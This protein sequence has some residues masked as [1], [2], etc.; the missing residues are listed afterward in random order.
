[1]PEDAHNCMEFGS[2][3]G[4][5][6][7][8]R[9]PK[10]VCGHG[11]PT[12]GVDQARSLAG[13]TQR[14]VEQIKGRHWPT[15]AEE[16][17]PH[18]RSGP[19]V[20]EWPLGSTAPQRNDCAQRVSGFFVKQDDPFLECLARRDSE[21]RCAVRVDVEAVDCQPADLATTRARPAGDQQRRTLLWTWQTIDGRHEASQLVGR[22]VARDVLR[23]ARHI[24]VI[25]Q[26]PAWHIGPA[27]AIASLKNAT[28][29]AM[30]AR[31]AVTDSNL[32]VTDRASS[33]MAATKP[34]AWSRVRSAKLRTSGAD[35][36]RCVMK[37]R[38]ETT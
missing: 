9:V 22:D 13:I 4:E 26:R 37:W 16:K 20:E 30:R 6:G 35:L 3:L 1:M 31:R 23:C 21:P 24:P 33:A 10:P 7:A 14:V 27:Q 12:A 2:S 38:S 11:G 29:A 8:Y 18:L 25:E 5:L 36:A 34:S 32:P 15:T 28:T 17:I 19:I